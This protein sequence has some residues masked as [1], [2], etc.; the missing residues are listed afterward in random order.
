MWDADRVAQ[1]LGN[2]LS[3][4]VTYSPEDTPVAVK[5]SGDGASVV[6][7]VHNRGAP[8]PVHRLRHI[9][10]PMQQLTPNLSSASRSV[11]LGLYIVE[12]ICEAHQGAVS[13]TSAEAEG[14]TFTI[15]LPKVARER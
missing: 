8:I 5:V 10:E 13:V 4:A 2:L 12:K 14:T 9:F 7:S 6:L 15:T 1:A 3:N 11:G